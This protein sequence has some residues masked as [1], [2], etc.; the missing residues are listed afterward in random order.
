MR[1][2]VCESLSH[3]WLFWDPMDYSLPGSS[4]HG[5]LQGR[6]LEWV[7][8]PFSRGTSR[9][10]L[11]PGSPALQADYLPSELPGD[12]TDN[13]AASKARLPKSSFNNNSWD[14]SVMRGAVVD[15]WDNQWTK[16]TE[17]PAL[18]EFAV[19][20]HRQETI[21]T[22]LFSLG[23]HT[24]VTSEIESQECC[25]GW[26]KTNQNKMI[27]KTEWFVRTVTYSTRAT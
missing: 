13:L 16:K 19:V 24:Q 3:V 12:S 15:P 18:L 6:I 25:H 26:V 27:T 22:T 8:I 23:L 20:A 11:E 10:G 1:A 9:P 5:I 2:C 21:Y 17:T 14:A 7:A 4:V